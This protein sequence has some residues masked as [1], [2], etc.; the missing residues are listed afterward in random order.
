MSHH[1]NNGDYLLLG[2]FGL[3]LLAEADA[4][5]REEQ[6]REEERREQDRREEEEP[7]EHDE[8]GGAL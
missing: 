3:W 5:E 1:P 8:E 4:E 6:E 7:D 2:L